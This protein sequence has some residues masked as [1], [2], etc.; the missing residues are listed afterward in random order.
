[1]PVISAA[2]RELISAGVS[3]EE[4]VQAIERL[5]VASYPPKTARQERNHRYYTNR[6]ERLKA[7]EIKTIKAPTSLKASESKTVASELRRFKTFEGEGG[8]SS[9]SDGV[10]KK[11]VSKKESHSRGSKIPS[12]WRPTESHYDEG[13]KLGLDRATVDRFAE[14]MRLWA[15]ANAN[16]AVARKSDWNKT[17]LVWLRRNAPATKNLIRPLSLSEIK[18]LET[19]DALAKLQQAVRDRSDGGRDPLD[20][21]LPDHERERSQRLHAGFGGNVLELHA[22]DRHARHQSDPWDTGQVQVRA[23]AGR[24]SRDP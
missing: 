8:P 7:S 16:R 3:G 13:G 18:Q 14:D 24:G 2:L 15:E 23:I 10:L 21:F 20:R 12:E 4:L 19:R 5:E 17:F 6:K 1:M 22:A 11:E 9:S